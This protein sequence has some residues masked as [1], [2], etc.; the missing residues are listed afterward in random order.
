MTNRVTHDA[1]LLDYFLA[2]H[3]Q[4]F[5]G[6]DFAYLQA[7]R[8]TIRSQPGW[9]YTAIVRG[10][11]HEAAALLDMDT[12]GGEFLAS[13]APLP[14]DTTA[15][16][17]YTPNIP[18]ATQRLASLGVQVLAM[19]A[20]GPLAFSDGR[21][22]LVT[23]RHGAY[24]PH[25]V[26]RVLRQRARFITQ[27]VASQTNAYLHE[28]LE[29]HGKADRWHLAL[30]VRQLKAAGFRI[31]EQREEA[32]I[33]RYHD[34]GAIVYYLKAVPWEIPDFTVERY[35]D[36]LVAIHHR[37]QADGPLDVPFHTFL[38]VAEAG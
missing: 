31:V 4:P 11:M 13:L 37:I 9:D 8:E 3:R 27:Q 24:L 28:L 36:H 12:G 30:A 19:D 22:D 18:L 5:S 34:V 16:E 26:H 20:R 7:R 23:N 17:G 25:E 1:S 29:G 33:T 38:I 2:E 32:S 35:Y 14:P 21:F 15:I 6:W 10:A